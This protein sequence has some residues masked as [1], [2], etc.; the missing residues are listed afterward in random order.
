[1][2][3]T[4]KPLSRHLERLVQKR[5]Q[6]GESFQLPEAVSLFHRLLSPQNHPP[7]IFTINRL[8]FSISKT[9]HSSRYSTVSLLFNRFKLT[10]DR[11]VF[12]NIHTFG[13]VIDCCRRMGRADLGFCVLGQSLR[14][15]CGVDTIMFGSLIKGLCSLKQ[16]G[17]AVKVFAK[18][19]LMGCAPNLIIYNTLIEGLCST[20]DSRLGHELCRQ[21][22]RERSSYMPDVITYST[23]I[24]GFCKEG[25]IGMAVEMFKEMTAEEVRPD[26]ITC[27]IL[28]DGLC[29][30]GDVITARKVIEEMPARSLVPNL[31][32]GSHSLSSDTPEEA[33]HE[34]LRDLFNLTLLNDSCHY[35]LH[36]K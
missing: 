15:G 5:I 4:V 6:A 14:E 35:L 36:E 17:L 13:L 30:N 12:P 2:A 10:R 8:L 1:M 20:G 3:N 31:H 29:K 19:P 11:G 32:T 7:S 26:V 18:T 28:I 9:K 33:R 25:E 23:L 21:M 16:I 27:N 24:H 22:A 34:L